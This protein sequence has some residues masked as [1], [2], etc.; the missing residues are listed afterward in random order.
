MPQS[1][2]PFDLPALGAPPPPAVRERRL[3]TEVLVNVCNG[4]TVSLTGELAEDTKVKG[5]KVDQ[6]IRAHLTGVGDLGNPYKLDLDVHSTWDTTAMTMTHRNRY[7]LDSK[8]PAPDQ[9]VEVTIRSSPLSIEI[10][11]ECHGLPKP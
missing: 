9:R 2:S 6:H 1:T 3:I 10:K 11:P 4:E 7:V 8:G 5:S